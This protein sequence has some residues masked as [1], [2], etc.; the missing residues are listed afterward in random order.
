LRE[1]PRAIPGERRIGRRQSFACPSLVLG[2][3][4]F[5]AVSSAVRAWLH[6]AMTRWLLIAALDKATIESTL[7]DEL[8]TSSGAGLARRTATMRQT[9]EMP[10]VSQFVQDARDCGAR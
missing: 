10:P 7:R 5:A 2:R 1:T 9:A 6:W 3:S 8:A 4:E